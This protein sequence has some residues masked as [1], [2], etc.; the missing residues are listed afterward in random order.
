MRR[1][2]EPWVLWRFREGANQWEL[3]WRRRLPLLLV[4][5]LAVLEALFPSRVWVTL[6]VAFGAVLAMSA[7]WARQM[8][9]GIR[10]RRELRYPLV[11]VGDLLE[12]QFTVENYSLL[13][14]LWVELVDHS[15]LPE[16]DASTVRAVGSQATYRWT[17][18]DLCRR[19][20]EFRLGPWEAITSDP[21]GIFA[22][23]QSNTE[24]EQV[25]V[26]PPI[27]QRLPFRL[28]RGATAGLAHV[29]HRSWEP[30]VTIGGVRAYVH[31]DPRHHIHW[32]TTAR[33]AQL[34]AKE[35]DQETGGDV[36]VVLDL[37][38]EVQVGRD[39][40]ST[41][42]M[43]VIVAG[44]AASLM[45]D[46]R[47]AVGLAAYGPDRQLVTPGRGR[48]H[49]WK[50]LRVLA[51]VR[52][53]A[54]RPLADVLEE[55]SRVLPPGSTA[56][57]VTP[58]T[59]PA[60]VSELVRLRG[61]GIG[62]SV[63]LLDASSFTEPPPPKANLLAQAAGLGLLGH[64][65]GPAAQLRGLLADVQ[66]NVEVIDADAPLVLRPPTGQVRRWEFKVLATG[67]ALAVT[68]PLE[69]VV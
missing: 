18:S 59:D 39:G 36:W 2:L 54:V 25:L 64:P 22:A 67:R 31:G 47:R 46:A 15:D 19:R 14:A 48:A 11:Q 34:F 21:F 38:R 49:L 44:S 16:Y 57:V 52:A 35:F 43:G 32:P 56:L 50:V 66:V 40:R 9:R 10:V 17:K 53:A 58:S 60:W 45:L 61:R 51:R 27:A 5:A 63:V 42:E 28:P 24:V 13:P 1:A 55:M 29:S 23:V 41:E 69:R 6:L 12:E 7:L 65:S 26:Y 8:A 20:G 4:V 33:R 62:A 3:V 68:S 37:D 30:T